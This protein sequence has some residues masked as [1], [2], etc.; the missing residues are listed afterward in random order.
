MSSER[1]S[2]RTDDT[3]LRRRVRTLLTLVAALLV[4]AWAAADTVTS[5]GTLQEYEAATGQKITSFSEAPSLQAKVAAGELPPVEERLP[6]EPMVLAPSESIGEYGGTL[7]DA[8]MG[9]GDIGYLNDILFE[10]PVTYSADMTDIVPNIF[11]DWLIEDGGKKYTFHIREGIKWSDGAPFTA[12]DFMFW[13]EAIA[14]NT[15]INPKGLGSLKA[16]GEMGVMEKIGDFTIVLTFVE[17]HGLLLEKMARWRPVPYAPAH[18]LRQFHPDYTPQ[19]EIDKAMAAEGFSDWIAFFE[20]HNSDTENPDMPTISAWKITNDVTQ[21]VQRLVRNPYYWKVDTAGNQLP[22]IDGIDRR[23]VSD[24]EALLLVVLA[25]EVDILNGERLGFTENLSVLKRNEERGSYEVLGT[26]QW[27]DNLGVVYFNYSHEDPITR[28][29]FNDKRFRVALSVAMDRDEINRVVFQGMYIPSQPAPPDGP[30]YYGERPEFKQYTEYDPQLA[31]QLLDAMGLVW[32]DAHTVRLRPDGKPLQL[33]LSA[34][35]NWVQTVPISEMYKQ[36]WAEI[37]VEITIKPAGSSF[38]KQQLSAS[39]HEL[40]IDSINMGGFRPILAG[41]RNQVVPI[42]TSWFMAPAWSTYM[43]TD[44][45]QGVEPPADVKR[46]Y[47]LH[48]AFLGEADYESRVAIEKEIYYIHTQNTWA[49]SAVKNPPAAYFLPVT[50]RL[51]NVSRPTA[52]EL[53]PTQP[54]SWFIGE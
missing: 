22:Y 3:T 20:W 15:D 32:N 14:S 21:P 16:G 10:F 12:D 42:N 49:I 4:T 35:D 31:N 36:Y 23:L 37:G 26:T 34:R 48:Q 13:Y 1:K 47:E 50:N 51:K 44:G 24:V 45:E 54:A 41:D 28:E 53:Y 9:R 8:H 30:P 52:L 27:A 33:I 19:D 6:S 18:Y 7:Q 43:V 25:G 46:L 38:W 5:Y 40:S 2:M 17:P 39:E 29:I 11:T